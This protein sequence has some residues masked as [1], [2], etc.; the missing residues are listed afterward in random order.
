MELVKFSSPFSHTYTLQWF[1]IAE[2]AC[3]HIKVDSYNFHLGL[4][5]E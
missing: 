1:G 5:N 3:I 4:E 2:M